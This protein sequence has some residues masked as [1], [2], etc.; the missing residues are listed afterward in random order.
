MARYATKEC[1]RCGL[2]RPVP[3]MRSRE[4][5]VVSGKSGVSL[6][7]NPSRDNSMRVHG[8]RTYKRRRKN[9]YC[10]EGC[11]NP[12]HFAE[13]E[14]RAE[15]AAQERAEQEREREQAKIQQ[16]RRVEAE[17]REITLLESR[18]TAKGGIQS[19]VAAFLQTDVGT[20]QAR[21]AN[22]HIQ[23]IQDQTGPS[24]ALVQA[25]LKH[26]LTKLS[27]S[28]ILRRD[29]SL[30]R[31][32]KATLRRLPKPNALRN[33]TLSFIA[34]ALRLALITCGL[35]TLVAAFELSSGEAGHN[36]WIGALILWVPG[37]AIWKLT[38]H[39]KRLRSEPCEENF[40]ALGQIY[41]AAT[42]NFHSFILGQLKSDEE[43]VQWQSAAAEYSSAQNLELLHT[44]DSKAILDVQNPVLA[45]VP[46]PINSATPPVADDS[47]ADFE[48]LRSLDRGSF[49]AAIVAMD[50]HLGPCEAILG[51]EIARANGSISPEEMNALELI[52]Q[53]DTDEQAIRDQ[54]RSRRGS[55]AIA[56][57]VINTD[58]N[59]KF[60]DKQRIIRNLYLIMDADGKRLKSE[61]KVL[62][63]VAEELRLR[64]YLGVI[65]EHLHDDSFFA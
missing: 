29:A 30:S 12:N 43:T 45:V 33:F 24:Q 35:F 61:Y 65:E 27:A 9:W 36:A 63:R 37:F 48:K 49:V 51:E 3:H 42:D 38:G 54:I 52:F 2:R 31:R 21:V 10:R 5:W 41:E 23:I 34:R 25:Q 6:S 44:T 14:A 47:P 8:G 59:T 50:N 53:L 15:R 28:L 19:A 60:E 22:R 58:S 64:P 26:F 62:E 11:G 57:E 7:F 18:I 17:K 13:K 40:Q 46:R 32:I 4:E 56:L 20:R 16:K 1:A 39:F 55:M